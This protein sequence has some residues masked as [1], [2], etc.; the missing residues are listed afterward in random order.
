LR[1]RDESRQPR[2][3]GRGHLAAER[4]D[5]VVA[6]PFVV[7]DPC[8]TTRRRLRETCFHEAAE[9]A[10]HGAGLEVE[11]ALGARFGFLQDRVSVSLALGEGEQ[12]LELDGAERWLSGHEPNYVRRAHRFHGP[13]V[14]ARSLARLPILGMEAPQLTVEEWFSLAYDELRRLAAGVRGQD[15]N[16]TLNPT[17]LVHEAFIRLASIHHVAPE[18]RLHFMMIAARAMRRVLVDAARQR[19]AG[20]RG[21]SSLLIT[22]EDDVGGTPERSEEVLALDAALDQLSQRDARASDVVL[23]RYFGGFSVAETAK[24]LDISEST[25]LREWQFARAWLDQ[26]LSRTN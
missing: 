16:Q 7:G 1:G 24:A 4:R 19:H 8:R 2:R 11:R 10:I 18:S 12:D 23:Y 25:V 15:P 9:R 20:K 26:Q 21:G 3:L 14:I 17:A 5:G 13:S 6:T 22:L